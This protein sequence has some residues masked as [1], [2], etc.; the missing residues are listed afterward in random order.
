MQ[1]TDPVALAA[2]TGCAD[3]LMAGG[4]YEIYQTTYEK[5]AYELSTAE[6]ENKAAAP[7]VDPDAVMFQYKWTEDEGAELFGPYTAQQM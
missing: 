2:L 3:E 4:D 1:T 5:L 6:E 7:A